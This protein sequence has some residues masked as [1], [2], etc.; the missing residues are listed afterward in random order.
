[1]LPEVLLERD[2]S[3]HATRIWTDN[4]DLIF[5]LDGFKEVREAGETTLEVIEDDS[6][7][8]EA[9]CLERMKVDCH[10]PVHTREL[11]HA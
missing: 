7:R 3:L 11:E 8:Y 10:D 2:S 1:M 5:V 9:L 4:D 6:A